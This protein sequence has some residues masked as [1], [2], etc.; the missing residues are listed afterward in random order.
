MKLVGKRL[1]GR[2]EIIEQV[3]GGGMAVVYKAMDTALGRHVAVKVMNDSLSQDEDFIRR[4]DREAR[5]AGSLS[6]PNVVNVF[7]VGSEGHTH[8]IVMEYIEGSSLMDQIRDQGRIPPEEAIQIAAQVCEG[9][10]HAHEKGI[11]HRDI[12]PHNIMSTL[13]ARYKLADFG[14]SRTTGSSTITKTGYVMGSVHYFSPEQ[15]RSKNV[16][17]QSDLYSLGVVLYEMVTGEIPFDGD[18]AVAIAL[19]HLQEPVPDPRLIVPD[20]P[21]SLCEV[22]YRAMEKSPEHRFQSAR[23]M[24]EF[25]HSVSEEQ[26]ESHPTPAPQQ[27]A[28]FPKEKPAQQDSDERPQT[29]GDRKRDSLGSHPPARKKGG[30]MKWFILAMTLVFLSALS[31]GIFSLV[32]LWDTPGGNVGAQ[33]GDQNPSGENQPDRQPE[34]NSR[35]NTDTQP[36]QENNGKPTQPV[37]SNPSPSKGTEEV[38]ED[39]PEY[40]WR[41]HDSESSNPSFRNISV[42]GSNGDYIVSVET[43]FYPEFHYDVTVFDSKGARQVITQAAVSTEGTESGFQTVQFQVKV[44]D[45]PQQGLVTI[46]LHNSGDEAYKILERRG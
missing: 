4:F 43:N 44:D 7:D 9:L 27:E 46:R 20:L 26:Q 33:S 37:T 40:D 1:G 36:D 21:A 2:Y 38:Q 34:E 29:P 23:E 10:A 42:N 45:L 13:D 35:D 28:H 41:K 5:A 18:E 11:V 6:H 16:S 25:I 24:L 15:A 30:K 12:K 19:Q 3:G 17:Y 14:I 8:Y 39:K 22:I 32:H 31:F